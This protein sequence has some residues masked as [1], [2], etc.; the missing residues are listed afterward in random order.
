VTSPFLIAWGDVVSG[1]QAL[2]TQALD[3]EP[4]G[5][6]T[7]AWE[8]TLRELKVRAL[9][10]DE[11]L[12]ACQGHRQTKGAPV[13]EVHAALDALVAARRTAVLTTLTPR[14]RAVASAGLVTLLEHAKAHYAQQ[15]SAPVKRGLFKHAKADAAK[16]QYGTSSKP[17]VYVMECPTCRGPRQSE[18]LSCVFC[19]A[20]W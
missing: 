9:A 2:V 13:P 7:V 16:H 4:L 5:G 19:N 17:E 12:P 10:E 11:R 1:V 14:Q 20:E 6:M 3:V 18:A 8:Q 15:A